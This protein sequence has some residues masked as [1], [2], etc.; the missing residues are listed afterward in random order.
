[1]V[2]IHLGPLNVSSGQGGSHPDE[3]RLEGQDV[4]E[5]KEK[6]KGVFLDPTLLRHSRRPNGPV[7]AAVQPRNKLVLA[8]REQMS[9][10]VVG[11]S[12]IRVSHPTAAPSEPGRSA[13]TRHLERSVKH[14]VKLGSEASSGVGQMVCG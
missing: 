14:Q 3:Y 2:Q 11:R 4:F 12:D 5:L 1:M 6:L 13:A 9:V 7:V 10:E 8:V